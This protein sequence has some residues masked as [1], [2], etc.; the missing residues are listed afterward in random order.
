[1]AFCL[2]MNKNLQQL[3]LENIE[4]SGCFVDGLSFLAVCRIVQHEEALSQN[5]WF[6]SR[7]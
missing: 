5:V 3:N 2:K 4:L 6:S 1:M 7:L